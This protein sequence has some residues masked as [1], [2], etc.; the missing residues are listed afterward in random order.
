MA[1]FLSYIEES[2]KELKDNVTWPAWKELQ[3]SS[4]LVLVASVIIALVVFVMD[5]AFGVQRFGGNDGGFVWKG[6]LG[7]FYD[8][9]N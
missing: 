9:F 5:F 1:K 7:F 3:E 8:M 4:V 2:F 6:L